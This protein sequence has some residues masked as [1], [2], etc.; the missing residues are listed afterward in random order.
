[1]IEYRSRPALRYFAHR[2]VP[3][4]HLRRAIASGIAAV[5]RMRQGAVE[6]PTSAETAG[7]GDQLDRL[8]LAMLPPVPAAAVDDMRR[9]FETQEFAPS[10]GFYPLPV[11]LACPGVQT[12]LQRADILRIAADYLGC[13]PTLSSIAVR[14]SLP[15][16]TRKP[17]VQSFHRDPDDWRHLK[18]FVYLT[19]VD[20]TSGPHVYVL[21][22]HLTSSTLRARA[23]E[24]DDV[25]RRFGT[26]NMQPVLG[27][28]GTMFVAD[29]HGV[30]MA[31]PA[32]L[33][34]RL[35][36][37]LQYSLLPNYALRY[38]PVSLPDRPELAT[39]VNRLIVYAPGDPDPARSFS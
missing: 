18:V 27:P 35:I 25:G 7:A 2:L 4:V 20:E 26:H 8:G 30:H 24:P 13:R 39:W 28:R 17:M 32:R 19:D 16:A 15:V 10:S 6:A 34:P 31:A 37:I 23:Y 14:W 36:L 5:V 33:R 29:T 9:F 12:I 11:V 3:E 38:E 1:M 22:S 21:Q